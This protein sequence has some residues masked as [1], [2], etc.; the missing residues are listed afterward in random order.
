[1]SEKR[2]I[3]PDDLYKMIGLEDPQISPDGRWVAFVH[4]TPNAMDKN[5]TRNIWLAATDGSGA[6][7]Y[8]RSGKDSQPRWS[9]DGTR[10]AFVSARGGKPQIYVLPVTAPGGEPRALTSH[11][12]GATG[13][14]WSPDSAH[15]AFSGLE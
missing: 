14:V 10:L 8:T 1:M 2:P 7:Q 11:A 5:Y 9:P 6:R 13:P 12:N 15:I 3:T 4:A